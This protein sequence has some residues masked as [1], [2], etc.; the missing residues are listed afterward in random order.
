MDSQKEGWVK[1]NGMEWNKVGKGLENGRK[2][3]REKGRVKERKKV[4]RVNRRKDMKKGR[5]AEY[6]NKYQRTLIYV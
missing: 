6:V 4:G 5:Q 3:R 2:Y 1:Q